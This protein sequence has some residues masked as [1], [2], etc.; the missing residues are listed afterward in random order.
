M[1]RPGPA[2]ARLVAP[3]NCT[4][5]VRVDGIRRGSDR[6]NIDVVPVGEVESVEVQL[7]PR[8][9]CGVVMIRTRR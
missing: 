6:L 4:L 2:E 5:D 1:E 8:G 3:R 7:L 9:G